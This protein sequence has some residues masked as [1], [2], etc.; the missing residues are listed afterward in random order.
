MLRVASEFA[1]SD[2]KLR[3]FAVA[4]V[5]RVHHLLPD[6]RSRQALEVA[7]QFADGGAT[8]LLLSAAWDAAWDAAWA[9][10]RDTAWAAA[11]DAARA[12]AWTVARD[13]A[14]AAARDTAWA[15]ARDAA[16]DAAWAAEAVLLREVVG[17]PFQR[18]EE[19]CGFVHSVSQGVTATVR[20]IASGAYDER[21]PDGTLDP[22]R[23]AVLADALEEAG[24][25]SEPLLMHLRGLEPCRRS[26]GRAVRRDRGAIGTG[27]RPLRTPHVRGCWALD[28]IL[29]KLP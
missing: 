10:S 17:N 4:C 6:P 3:L 16:R 1:V 13:A 8:Q 28:A 14:R 21:L 12:A 24:C 23:L 25:D 20:S 5:R 15:A 7:E 29:G 27:W 9:V 19:L 2:R 11:R 18:A 22:L 26:R